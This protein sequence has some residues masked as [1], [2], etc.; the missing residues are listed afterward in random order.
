MAAS[1]HGGKAE[2]AASVHHSPGQ[3]SLEPAIEDTT[4]QASLSTSR[5]SLQEHDRSAET[6][7]GRETLTTNQISGALLIIMLGSEVDVIY[8]KYCRAQGV[9]IDDT[10]L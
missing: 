5:K 10:K 8:S 2:I 3:L 7:C 4:A 6:T 9:G 1:E